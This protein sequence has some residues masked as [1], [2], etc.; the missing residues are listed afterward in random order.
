[1]KA[2]YGALLRYFP[3][4]CSNFASLPLLRYQYYS[5]DVE[6]IAGH[7][8][9]EL[10]RVEVP[11]TSVEEEGMVELEIAMSHRV[12]YPQMQKRWTQAIQNSRFCKMLSPLFGTVLHTVIKRNMGCT[13]FTFFL[14]VSPAPLTTESLPLRCTD[15]V[16]CHHSLQVSPRN[17]VIPSLLCMFLA[18]SMSATLKQIWKAPRPFYIRP[19]LLK[20][21]FESWGYSSPSLHSTMAAASGGG[22]SQI[23]TLF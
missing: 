19:D 4:E 21:G 17:A 23:P 1:M 14:T 6:H 16:D 9:W 18:G 12:P 10:K 3:D 13:M 11:F 22:D 7:L 2:A 5:E 8:V 15:C 20:D